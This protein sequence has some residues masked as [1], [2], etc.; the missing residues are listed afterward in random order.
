MYTASNSFDLSVIPDIAMN[1]SVSE[2]ELAGEVLN[3]PTVIGV[4]IA[5]A[6]WI[7]DQIDKLT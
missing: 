6:D 2:G 4:A 3:I 1:I 5:I 7:G